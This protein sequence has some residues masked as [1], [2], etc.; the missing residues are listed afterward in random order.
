MPRQTTRRSATTKAKADVVKKQVEVNA[1]DDVTVE[2]ETKPVVN[3]IEKK[4]FEPEDMIACRSIIP[5]GVYMEGIKSKMLYEFNG[6]GDEVDVEYRDLVAAVNS[7]SSFLFNPF[8]VVL[9]D[10]FISDQPKLKAFYDSMYSLEDIEG[11]LNYDSS[12]IEKI[13]P[14]L[15]N[16]ARESLKSIAAT[17]IANGTL[18]SV[19]KIK[20][21]DEFFN[22]QLMLLTDLYE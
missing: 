17:K 19:A 3:K 8:I 20:V 9:D 12:D 21:L 6:Y 22:T 16:G 11:I 2:P 18:D 15:P 10:E 13:L 4:H 5:G 1:V 7:K 14:Q